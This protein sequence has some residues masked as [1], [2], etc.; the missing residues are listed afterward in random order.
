MSRLKLITGPVSEPIT[1]SEARAHLRIDATGSPATH[2]EDAYVTSLIKV[3]RQQIDGRDGW[4]GRQLMPATWE[5][6][7]DKFPANEI[8]I[9][10]PPIQSITSVKY[11]DPDGLE[12]TVDP[13]NYD[14]DIDDPSN[15][16]WIT[17]NGNNQ[18]PSTIDAIN[19]VR[20]RYV[21]GY[22]DASSIPEP[23]KQAMLLMIGHLY[24]NRETSAMGSASQILPFGY[25]SLLKQ[26]QVWSFP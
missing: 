1:L 19:A 7:I 21:A 17:P 4:L 12:Q 9:P 11:D 3:V 22:A 16:G 2:P 5:L 13:A 26:F 18:W 14:V 15:P 10:L 8:R 24:E 25:E 6:I 23:I 20:V